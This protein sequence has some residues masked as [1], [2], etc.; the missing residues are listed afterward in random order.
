MPIIQTSFSQR[1]SQLLRSLPA[2]GRAEELRQKS[3]QAVDSL[4][5]EFPTC[6]ETDIG[7]L[8]PPD[9]HPT[10]PISSATTPMASKA[11]SSAG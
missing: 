6:P 11:E 5:R 8:A 9:C 2:E 1:A 3:E 7:R 10:A 4:V